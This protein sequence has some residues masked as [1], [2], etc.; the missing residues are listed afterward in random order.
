M[1]ETE[2]GDFSETIIGRVAPMGKRNSGGGEGICDEKSL[3]RG[4]NMSSSCKSRRLGAGTVIWPA[5]S[6]KKER[7]ERESVQRRKPR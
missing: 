2:A 1:A 3:S 7:K 5:T 4:F 6:R